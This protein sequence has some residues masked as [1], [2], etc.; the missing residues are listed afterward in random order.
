[1]RN[2]GALRR[3]VRTT[4]SERLDS[5]EAGAQVVWCPKQVFTGRASTPRHLLD[6][7]MGSGHAVHNPKVVDSNLPPLPRE[8]PANARV[9]SFRGAQPGCSFAQ[10]F[11]WTQ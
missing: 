11:A 8:T 7:G 1:M 5:G 6:I 4:R 2:A 10:R 9:S 3:A